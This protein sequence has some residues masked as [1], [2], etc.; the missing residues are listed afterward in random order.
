MTVVG[1]MGRQSRETTYCLR[2]ILEGAEAIHSFSIIDLEQTSEMKQVDILVAS[3]GSDIAQSVIESQSNHF[4]I[5]NPDQ[6]D[7]LA[8]AANSRGL[9]ITYGFNKK[10]CVT[11]SSVMEN[12]IQICVQRDLPT[13]SGKTIEQQEFGIS[14]DTENRSPENLLA[15]ITA[16]LV[17]DVQVMVLK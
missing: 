8:Y 3:G 11:A 7:I 16:A 9:L 12:E 6:K 4:F 5:M 13:I 1:I 15:A 10:V 2:E 17:A 14:M